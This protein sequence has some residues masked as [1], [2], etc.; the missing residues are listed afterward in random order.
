MKIHTTN[1]Y[2]V[3]IGI[4]KNFSIESI[5]QEFSRSWN[6][7]R[8]SSIYKELFDMCSS[9]DLFMEFSRPTILWKQLV[10]FFLDLL[11]IPF[12][13]TL[14]K[15]ITWHFH[16]KLPYSWQKARNTIKMSKT[17]AIN[18]C[19][20]TTISW[21]WKI[22]CHEKQIKTIKK[23]NCLLITTKKPLSAVPRK[24]KN[25]YLILF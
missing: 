13:L 17:T 15:I 6:P 11:F 14:D 8:C 20:F 10:N 16:E 2:S 4:P 22:L 21:P 7:V 24:K 3:H 19:T 9:T 12:S 23:K 1:S 18:F 25:I 5:L